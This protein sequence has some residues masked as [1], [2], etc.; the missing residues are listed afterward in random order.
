MVEN[1]EQSNADVQVQPD[2]IAGVA[3]SA[4]SGAEKDLVNDTRYPHNPSASAAVPILEVFGASGETVLA[5]VGNAGSSER[6]PASSDLPPSFNHYEHFPQRT[7]LEQMKIPLAGS[8]SQAFS[9]GEISRDRRG[10]MTISFQ[11]RRYGESIQ[12]GADG[13]IS[14]LTN[15]GSTQFPMQ[16]VGN[17]LIITTPNGNAVTLENGQIVSSQTGNLLTSFVP[18][19]P[20]HKQMSR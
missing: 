15:Y 12:V 6:T 7:Q 14:T 5:L 3:Q 9:N 1:I 13:S 4:Y 16:Q 18:T 19:A 8:F 17:S 10:N 2:V 11:Q 20:R